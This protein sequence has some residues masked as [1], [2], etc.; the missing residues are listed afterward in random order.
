MSEEEGVELPTVRFCIS[1][2]A[3]ELTVPVFLPKASKSGCCCT[4]VV[5]FSKKAGAA[6]GVSVQN[7]YQFS[8]IRSPPGVYVELF[9]SVPVIA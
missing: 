6:Y 2:P 8:G 9:P 5:R 4:I 7:V 1:R 3:R